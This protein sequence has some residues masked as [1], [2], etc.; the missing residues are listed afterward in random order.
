[1]TEVNHG[2][3]LTQAGVSRLCNR[4]VRRGLVARG[5]DP[6]D[7]RASVLTLTEKGAALQRAVGA[8]HARTVTAAMTEA[9]TPDQLTQLRTLAHQIID[10]IGPAPTGHESQDST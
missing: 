3:L 10:R 8:R 6:S 5:C 2:I 4:L 9:L 7:R 1:M